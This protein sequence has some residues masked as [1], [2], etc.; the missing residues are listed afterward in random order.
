MRPLEGSRLSG[1]LKPSSPASSRARSKRSFTA[2]RAAALPGCPARAACAACAACS[3][4]PRPGCSSPSQG[5]GPSPPPT[6]ERDRGRLALCKGEGPDTCSNPRHPSTP[7]DA[8]APF[9]ILC[10][11]RDKPGDPPELH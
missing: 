1:R 11:G 10:W 4:R 9:P 6:P 3:A 8:N 5:W 7:S 2:T